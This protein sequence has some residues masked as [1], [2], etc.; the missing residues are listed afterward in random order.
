MKK[1]AVGLLIGMV[2]LTGCTNQF[3]KNIKHTQ[4]SWV[5]LDR[6]VEVYS[7]DGKLLKTY[8]G[9]FKV[10]ENPNGSI[11]FITND[12]KEHKIIGGIVIIDEQ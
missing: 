10:E 3:G 1:L 8:E 12:N 5:G 6:K 11:S 4:S 2:L 7:L 9:R